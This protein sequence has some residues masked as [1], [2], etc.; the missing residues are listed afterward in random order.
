MET[1]V[2]SMYGPLEVVTSFSLCWP[3][4]VMTLGLVRHGWHTGCVCGDAVA[5]GRRLMVSNRESDGK[6][7]RAEA[8]REAARP[9]YTLTPRRGPSSFRY[10][11]HQEAVEDAEHFARLLPDAVVDL[12]Y[13]PSG[14][15]A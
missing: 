12:V 3:L 4:T 13:P 5:K 6:V 2:E 11:Y 15:R 7:I 1:R 14:Q 8:K 9:S 10:R